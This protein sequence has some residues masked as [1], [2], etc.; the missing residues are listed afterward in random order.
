LV[1]GSWLSEVPTTISAVKSKDHVIR[2]ARVE[3]EFRNLSDA[4]FAELIAV[5]PEDAQTALSARSGGEA[6]AIDIQVLR[7]AMRR[8]RMKGFPDQVAAAITEP[9][10]DAC[11]AALGDKADFPTEAELAATL[12]GLVSTYGVA[13][14]RLMLASA[15]LQDA[16]AAG[17]IQKLLKSNDIIAVSTP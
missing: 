7:D 10:L 15:A 4:R 2:L 16:P 1:G 9:C 6:G 17:S 5:L 11:I 12:P 14:V 8:A 13:T 3:A